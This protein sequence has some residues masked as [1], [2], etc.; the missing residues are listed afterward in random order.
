MVR[1]MSPDKDPRDRWIRRYQPNP[2]SAARLVCFPH[3]G[4]AASY[5]HPVARALA[6]VAEVLAVQYPG[7]Q[8]RSQEPLIDDMTAMADGAF[9]ALRSWDD[10][11][12]AFFGHSMGAIVAF[13]VAL[14]WQ[15]TLRKP[16]ALLVV[17][18]NRAPSNRRAPDNVHLE[19]DAGLM[20]DVRKLG[21][22]DLSILEADEELLRL[23]LPSIRSD[24]RAIELYEGPEDATLN[25]PIV[26]LTS[27][28]DPTVSVEE[29]REW[30]RHTT[31]SFDLHVYSGGHFYL[32]DHSA[33]I[34]DLLADRLKAVGLPAI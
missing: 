2:T 13:E 7:R 26:A 12:M 20:A 29:M 3:A 10:R 5:F 22:T 27:D 19:D 33:E 4:G 8:D 24:Y 11:P 15:R 23:I 31:R 6:P 1:A 28:D 18:G 34:N 30:Q 32:N 21:G 17:S 9:E 16:P 25:C 14:R